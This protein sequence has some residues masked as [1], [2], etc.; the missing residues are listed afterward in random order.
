MATATI[1]LQ[2]NGQQGG[3][4]EPAAAAAAAAAAVVAAG[5]KWKPPQ[6]ADS[7]KMEN[8]QST[9]TKL[10]LPPLTPEQ[11]EALQKAKK[12]A[13]E[14]SIKSVLVKQ[15]IAHQQQ[16]LTNLQMAAQRQRALAIMCR[17]YVGSIYYELG[18]DTIRQAFAPFGPIKSIDMSWDSVTMKHKGFAFVEYEVPEA[19]QLALEQMNSVMLGGRN[20]KV[21]RPSNIGQAQPIIDQ[22][23]EEA[24]AFNRIYVASVHQDLSDDDIKSV[25]EAFGKIKS[26]TLARDPTT[27]KHKGY[28]F[29]EYEKAQSSQDAVSSMNLFDLGGQYLRVGKAVT[30]PMPLLTPATPGGLPPAAA[31]AAAAAT[32]KITAQEAVAGAAVLGTLA[33]PGLVSPALTLAQPLGALP[34]A[35]MA[36]QAPGVITGV[37]PARP[38]IPVTIPSVGVVNPILA[39][40][41]TLGLLE[42]KKEKEEEELFPESERPEMLSEQEHMSISGSS[43]RH[44]VM[45]KL[46]RKQEST[47][48]VLRNMVDPKDIDDDL[49]GEVTEECGKFGAVNRVIIYQEKQGEEEDAEIIVKIFVEFSMASETHKAIQALNGRWFA[50][51]KVVAEVYDQERFDNSDLS[52]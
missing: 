42:P 44:M 32:A 52:A 11:Q 28:G 38:P 10:G 19:A 1:A 45:Q 36:A 37:T 2:V 49:E 50:G 24:R 12:Y 4:S 39:S 31:V 40:P 51:R 47:V 3:G 20:I 43:A 35:V 22:L 16:Q 27:G 6:G 46:L 30:P 34:Q 18:E 8:G 9:G 25:F 13:M 7:I 17:V 5:D 33:T 21:G 48:M 29:I 15:T 26:C 14:Q 41:P 23:A